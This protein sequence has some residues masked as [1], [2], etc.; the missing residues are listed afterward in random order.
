[1]TNEE[2]K[3]I[4]TEWAKKETSGSDKSVQKAYVELSIRKFEDGLLNVNEDGQVV[5]VGE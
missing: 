5:K 4:I 3:Q 1:M 2:K